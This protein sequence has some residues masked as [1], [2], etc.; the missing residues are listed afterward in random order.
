MLAPCMCRTSRQWPTDVSMTTT[1]S[2]NNGS[3]L[4]AAA[5]VA[6]SISGIW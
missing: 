1:V 3:A 6:P 5:S 4:I 2:L